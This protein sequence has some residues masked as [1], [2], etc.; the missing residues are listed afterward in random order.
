MQVNI[1]NFPETKVAVL[2]HRGVPSLVNES[3]STF[4]DWRKSSMLSPVKT[5]KTFGI[6]YDDPNVVAPADFRFDICGS[7]ESDVPQNPQ[8]IINKT[9]PG[10]CCAVVRH[11]GSHDYMDAKIYK[12]YGEWLPE[13]GE[14][15]RD[16]PFYFHYLNFFPEVE[17]HQLLT[18][19]Y[20]PIK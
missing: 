7:I 20:L 10:G 18:D 16:F 2:E 5:S 15:L 14:E 19:I 11:T 4:I 12:L 8:G 13:S 6:V 3:V 9:I 17:E 1:V